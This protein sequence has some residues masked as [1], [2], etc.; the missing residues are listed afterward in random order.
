MN[1]TSHACLTGATTCITS[2]KLLYSVRRQ[3]GYFTRFSCRHYMGRKLKTA[4]LLATVRYY[5]KKEAWWPSGLERWTGDRVVLGSNPAAPTSLRNFG[6]SV[7]QALLVSFGRYTKSRRSL[8]SGAYARGSKIT[9]QSALE[10]C[11]V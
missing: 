8:L 5:S 9:H 1:R 7:Y 10:M 6:N 2:I 11:S 3:S 4:L